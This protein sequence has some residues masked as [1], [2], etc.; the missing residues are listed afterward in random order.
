[1]A[2]KRNFPLLLTSRADRPPTVAE[3]ADTTV[4]VFWAS[5]Q[6]MGYG[7][8][9]AYFAP[10]NWPRRGLPFIIPKTV[11][12]LFPVSGGD[13][14]FDAGGDTGEGETCLLALDTGDCGSVGY[15]S[16]PDNPHEICP[17][18][19]GYADL[20]ENVAQGCAVIVGSVTH[21]S[22]PSNTGDSGEDSA[23]NVWKEIAR[24]LKAEL[25]P[26]YRR[27]ELEVLIHESTEV[28]PN[29]MSP[30]IDY[31]EFLGTDVLNVKI[32]EGPWRP[33]TDDAPEWQDGLTLLESYYARFPRHRTVVY[34]DVGP[35]DDEPDPAY[36]ENYA[37]SLAEIQ[38]ACGQASDLGISYGGE[39]NYHTP[40]AGLFRDLITEFAVS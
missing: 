27:K 24:T 22:G 11:R 14:A 28:W 10:L 23:K 31:G 15:G 40:N 36:Q 17:S 16:D 6:N 26:L 20:L 4:K 12:F 1:M 30:P 39:V 35:K 38:Q 25:V 37:K 3:V 7:A 5:E 21:G 2:V 33:I 9:F 29:M 34:L 32:V 18:A 19:E 8:D 13:N